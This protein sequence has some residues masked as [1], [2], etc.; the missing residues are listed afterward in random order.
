MLS[1]LIFPRWAT[2]EGTW[3]RILRLGYDD[4]E[5]V[6]RLGIPSTLKEQKPWKENILKNVTRD[7]RKWNLPRM[8]TKVLWKEAVCELNFLER[9]T[10]WL[11]R[12]TVIVES[13]DC[14]WSRADYDLSWA[15]SSWP[16]AVSDLRSLCYHMKRFTMYF[17]KRPTRGRL[18]VPET[19]DT[20]R[21][22]F[23]TWCVH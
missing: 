18:R 7:W 12:T 16:I 14:C 20:Y 4:V 6:C 22:G 8:W 9:L 5:M 13:L 3:W 21:R 19:P 11:I 17:V 23:P 2:K 1:C 15:R 10:Y